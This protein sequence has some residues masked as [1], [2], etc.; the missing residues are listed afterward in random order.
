[1]DELVT[2]FEF[3]PPWLMR[4][5]RILAAPLRAP[6]E[7]GTL[8]H[9]PFLTS[10]LLIAY[11]AYALAHKKGPVEFWRR[12]F[13]A[14]V[15]WH[16]SARADYRYYLV[17]GALFPLVFAP[18]FAISSLV[19]NAMGDAADIPA[20]T[21]DPGWGAITLY[22]V[23]FFIVY[24]F[25][26]YFAHWVQHKVPV[27][28]EFHK[29]HHSAEVLTPFTSFR[30]HPFDLLLMSV[31][32]GLCTGVAGGLTFIAVGARVDAYTLLGMHVGIAAYHVISNLRH[33]Q[34]WLSYGPVLSRILISP[35]QHQIHHS[36]DPR[37]FH[38]NIGWAFA[39]WDRLLGTLY[40]PSEEE[41]IV[42]GL[43]DGSEGEYHGVLRMYV[44]P[45][46]KIRAL[47]I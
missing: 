32:P 28:W 37:H 17:N 13:N 26:R 2:E 3:L 22:S 11:L 36:S 18:F 14:G 42:Y 25:G 27:L 47:W 31:V 15:W 23:V 33:S 39:F 16:P 19:A 30:I 12:Y 43:G 41:Q 7:S 24:D 8:L 9:W 10:A 20:I 1:M 45:F 34:V 35:A 44:L 40:V 38:K 6:F 46:A 21:R 29:I 5:G 4:L